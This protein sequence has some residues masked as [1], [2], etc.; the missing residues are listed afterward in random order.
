MIAAVGACGFIILAF[1]TNGNFV[2][3]NPTTIV[4]VVGSIRR[5]ILIVCMLSYL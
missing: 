1:V 4:M 5:S 2:D 3:W